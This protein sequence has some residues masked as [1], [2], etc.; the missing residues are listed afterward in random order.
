MRRVLSF[1]LSARLVELQGT[2]ASLLQYTKHQ[3]PINAHQR[4]SISDFLID[5][6][7]VDRRATRWFAAILAPQYG[8]RTSVDITDDD[9]SCV[10][11]SYSLLA[12]NDYSISS[13]KFESA[14]RT[15]GEETPLSSYEALKLWLGFVI[16]IDWAFSKCRQHFQQR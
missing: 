16:T 3:A 11:W 6:A 14:Q 5:V 12:E 15:M 2:K 13:R 4:D 1:I 8:F 7:D 10:P 9:L